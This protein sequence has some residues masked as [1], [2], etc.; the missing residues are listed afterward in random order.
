MARVKFENEDPPAPVLERRYRV[1]LPLINFADR[2]LHGYN[3]V[4]PG[5]GYLGRVDLGR[6]AVLVKL[7]EIESSRLSRE[8][9][10]EEYDG[11][12]PI[13]HRLEILDVPTAE[14]YQEATLLLRQFMLVVRAPVPVVRAVVDYKVGGTHYR[15]GYI[16]LDTSTRNHHGFPRSRIETLKALRVGM[17]SNLPQAVLRSLDHY[18]HS[19]RSLWRSD[20]DDAFVMAAVGFE[21]LLGHKLDS[22]ISY[23]LCLRATRLCRGGKDL[24]KALR[25][26]YSLRSKIVHGGK[27]ATG[28]NVTHLQQALMR[29]IPSV[30]ALSQECGSYDEAMA[31]L[32]ALALGSGQAEPRTISSSGWW[33]YVP[34]EACL[35]WPATEAGVEDGW[36]A[37]V[38]L[39]D[40]GPPYGGV[41]EEH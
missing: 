1:T 24:F 30:A 23:R 4:D 21:S 11:Y 13:D 6:N 34:I 38:R 28:E 32:D 15:G 25:T 17:G 10:Q 41:S 19:V 27:S 8:L 2:P 7:D 39:Y 31:T 12:W 33:S 14:I 22:E 16:A 35:N 9:L 29:L 20:L 5:S 3:D 18:D 26:L 37:D 40:Y 36:G